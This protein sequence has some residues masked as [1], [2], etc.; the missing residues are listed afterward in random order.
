M[1]ARTMRSISLPVVGLA[2]LALA[3]CETG[4]PSAD[5]VADSADA[6]PVAA[7]DATP[8]DGEVEW[9][10]AI[11]AAGADMTMVARDERS[12]LIL[13]QLVGEDP[14]GDLG[15]DTMALAVFLGPRPTGGYSVEFDDILRDG[16]DLVVDFGEST[17]GAGDSTTQAVTAPYIIQLVPEADGVV[18]F[19]RAR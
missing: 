6:S 7:T 10:G 3:G 12:W 9:S 8:V 15:D 16:D 4:V 2:V 14:P 13:W 11:A 17:P 19:R 1:I 5:Q 18:H